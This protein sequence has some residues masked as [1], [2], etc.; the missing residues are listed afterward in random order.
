MMENL[1]KYLI[2]IGGGSILLIR[3]CLAED[4]MIIN[5]VKES[6]S[7]AVSASKLGIEAENAAIKKLQASK[8]TA[9]IAKESRF[10]KKKKIFD[11]IEDLLEIATQNVNNSAPPSS[12]NK[13]SI[14]ARIVKEV[15]DDDHKE[16]L[17]NDFEEWYDE[18]NYDWE[19]ISKT[20]KSELQGVII[21]D[22]RFKHLILFEYSNTYFEDFCFK[23][24]NSSKSNYSNFAKV[25][26]IALS[27]GFTPNS[28]LIVEI[29]KHLNIEK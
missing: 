18:E 25:K 27:R 2:G 9:Q 5:A 14:A 10:F 13:G 23:Y 21:I 15:L 8:S 4:K 11:K 29:D 28:K 3:S 20:I 17:Q 26:A 19:R 12:P 7:A 16:S 24:V 22:P 6:E 1:K